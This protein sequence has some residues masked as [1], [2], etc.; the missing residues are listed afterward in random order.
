MKH[1]L[2]IIGSLNAGGA[3]KSLVSLL[4]TLEDYENQYYIDLM[5]LSEGDFFIKQIPKFV[6]FVEKPKHFE[7]C[8]HHLSNLKF[9]LKHPIA[10]LL[11]LIS[12]LLLLPQKK[13]KRHVW[14]FWRYF[15]PQYFT[16]YDVAIAYLETFPTY[17][18]IDKITAKRKIVW[19]HNDINKTSYDKQ[20]EYKYFKK[21]D[22]IVT[23]S[24]ECLYSLTTSFPDLDSKFTVIENISNSKLIKKLSVIPLHDER[25]LSKKIKLLSI[26]RLSEQK[27]FE[28]AI[29]SAAQLK[30]KG[31]DFIW[32]IL[33]DGK[34]YEKLQNLITSY[35]LNEYV[36]LAGTH[37]NPYQY[38]QA[39]DILIQTS[40]YEGKS[41]VLDEAKILLKPIIVTNYPTSKDIIENN[42]TGII[43]EMNA[44]S[45][46]SAIMR[47]L[48]DKKLQLSI[49]KNLKNTCKDNTAEINKY[50][51]IIEGNETPRKP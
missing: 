24:E 42:K 19:F 9:W 27:Q 40:K 6:N 16:K 36:I 22:K 50:I 38:M 11:K 30:D 47:L 12:C 29:E 35:A 31:I 26:G 28:L 33:G 10:F 18:V 15:I 7:F 8:Q 17:V 46:S 25:F 4:N 41:I 49:I 44:N 39:A 2:F 45:I 1:I 23:I 13:E 14:S 37:I 32:Y 20:Y 48:Q 51:S 34:L 5:L 21:A 43:C 3:E